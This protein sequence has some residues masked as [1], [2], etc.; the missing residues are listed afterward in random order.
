MF[1]CVLVC[2]VSVPV[3]V[4]LC[5]ASFVFVC[6]SLCLYQ[7]LVV[8]VRESV[9]DWV[10]NGFGAV[11]SG[12][13]ADDDYTARRNNGE[14]CYSDSGKYCYSAASKV[15]FGPVTENCDNSYEQPTH[16]V[17][18][19]LTAADF[20]GSTIGL[21]YMNQMGCNR[22]WVNGGYVR[23]NNFHNVGINQWNDDN[24]CSAVI[25]HGECAR[26]GLGRG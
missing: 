17:A 11:L 24:Q 26:G 22:Q 19:F 4:F 13:L 8:C 20:G 3:V 14:T 5:F 10:A 23:Q 2:T 6:I 21:A 16:D 12:P 18:H 1:V 7:C 9:S 25:T 15:C